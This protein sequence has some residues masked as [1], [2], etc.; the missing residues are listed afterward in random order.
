MGLTIP[1]MR[2][3]VV[4]ARARAG[5]TGPVNGAREV[6]REPCAQRALGFCCLFCHA[7][8]ANQFQLEL[9]LERGD[10]HLIARWCETHGAEGSRP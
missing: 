10:H 5:D 3:G 7:I 2:P 6:V 4:V 9:H 1:P 8:L